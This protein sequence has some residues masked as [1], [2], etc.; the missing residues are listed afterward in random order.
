MRKSFIVFILL[1]TIYYL[2]HTI[3]AQTATDEFTT[4]VGSPSGPPPKQ[5]VQ[6]GGSDLASQ[7]VTK[8]QRSNSCVLNNVK[9]V[10][11][12]ANVNVCVGS[13]K[14]IPELT[15][16]ELTFSANTYTFLQCVGFVQAVVGGITGN[17]FDRIPS[18]KFYQ[19][20]KSFIS[21]DAKDIIRIGDLAVWNKNPDGHVA[22]VVKV[23]DKKT[24]E[25]AEANW[26]PLGQVGFRDVKADELNFV[27][28]VRL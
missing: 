12:K 8:V 17:T 25:V 18:A 19:N 3:Y 1:Y 11:A 27:G 6:S 13:I 21:K 23:Y 22:Y 7:L 9:G 26:G 16:T 10:V 14:P 20:W 4:K 15:E 24:F 28:W 2:P 5:S